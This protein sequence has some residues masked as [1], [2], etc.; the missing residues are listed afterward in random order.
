MFQYNK[1]VHPATIGA[2]L[3]QDLTRRIAIAAL[4]LLSPNE[5]YQMEIAIVLNATTKISSS[6]TAKVCFKCNLECHF[7]CYTCKSDLADECLQCGNPEETLR[8]WSNEG[9]CSCI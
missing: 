2:S 1:H 8:E 9:I 4:K 6:K 5:N 7:S 3:V